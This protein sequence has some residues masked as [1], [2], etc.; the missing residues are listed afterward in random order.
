MYLQI[1]QNIVNHPKIKK[2]SRL[3]QLTKRDTI[4]LLIFL[5]SWCLEYAQ[6]GNIAKYESEDIADTCEWEN[7][8]EVLISALKDCRLLIQEEERLLI[9]SWEEYAGKIFKSKLKNAE[10]QRK[11]QEKKKAEKDKPL[12]N[13]YI[14]ISKPLDNDYITI[15][16]PLDN[17]IDKIRLDK[18]R[19]DNIK[20]EAP[21]KGPI[22]PLDTPIKKSK[23]E[24][25]PFRDI[26]E[27]WNSTIKSLP[28]IQEITDKR[29]KAL[30]TLC[31]GKEERKKID[32]WQKLFFDI[33]SNDFL[34]G[35]KT[36]WSADFDW[37]LQPE[38]FQ[39]IVEGSYKNNGKK[40]KFEDE[41]AREW[42]QFPLDDETEAVE[43]FSGGDKGARNTI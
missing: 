24:N 34:T 5:W 15:S 21:F 26:L 12:D 13:D 14:T 28:K 23:E 32:F 22:D 8:P 16:K 42:K 25:I 31:K 6:D 40:V 41:P 36:D 19:K 9:N 27:C 17:D 29:K 20:E 11:F 3:L 37:C 7:E 10:N 43:L 2:L 1:N 39:K 38:K 33:E 35:R 30:K 4:G 18:K